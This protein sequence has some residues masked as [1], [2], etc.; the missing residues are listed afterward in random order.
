M[1]LAAGVFESNDEGAST[2][3]N[4][5]PSATSEDIMTSF[6]VP[7]VS[8]TVT[9]VV[10]TISVDELDPSST[11]ND[12]EGP[13]S[14]THY[15]EDLKSTSMTS[16]INPTPTTNDGMGSSD[17]NKSTETGDGV[18]VRPTS[19]SNTTDNEELGNPD[20][21]TTTTTQEDV[22]VRFNFNE[23]LYRECKVSD[24][25]GDTCGETWYKCRPDGGS[26][27]PADFFKFT[28]A[29]PPQHWAPARAQ[30]LR[31]VVFNLKQEK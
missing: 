23:K 22:D 8:P 11:K 9:G 13:P 19:K 26:S 20:T 10:R 16:S 5:S 17:G 25:S 3:S 7:E 24:A 12:L 18:N 27:E 14:P 6:T 15:L 21:N 2:P 28:Q 30:A 29:N 1:L 4:T 31:S